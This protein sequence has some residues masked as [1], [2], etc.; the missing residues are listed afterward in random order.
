MR[1]TLGPKGRQV[2]LG[3][4][5]GLA[6]DTEDGASI[7]EAI[8]HADHPFA[9]VGSQLVKQVAVATRVDGWL[10]AV[11]VGCRRIASSERPQLTVTLLAPVT[12]TTAHTAS[13]RN[14]RLTTVRGAQV[15]HSR[16]KRCG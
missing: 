4:N 15:R 11:G 2:V 12:A 8:N 16:A 10:G 3:G 14:A 9:D 6:E 7:A 5:R 1:I 13:A